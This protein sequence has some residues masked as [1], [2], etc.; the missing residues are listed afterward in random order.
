MRIFEILNGLD[1]AAPCP[2]QPAMGWREIPVFR[3]MSIFIIKTRYKGTFV[4]IRMYRAGISNRP[5]HW[6]KMPPPENTRHQYRH[7]QHK[8]CMTPRAENAP[9]AISPSRP[10]TF[11]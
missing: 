1:F 7:Q 2:A 3:L 6:T 8:T 5:A 11:P 9:A 4:P 10:G